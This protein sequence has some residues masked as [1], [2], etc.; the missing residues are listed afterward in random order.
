[1]ALA[2]N[3]RHYRFHNGEMTQKELAELIGVS[4][5]TVN[6]IECNKSS[7]SL[8]A[9]FRIAHVLG[10]AIE[11]VF[12]YEPDIEGEHEFADGAIIDVSW[13]GDDDSGGNL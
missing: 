6:A 8:E 12:F 1:M 7:P 2:N 13:D 4:R 3:I 11:D 9:A 10:A 5:Q